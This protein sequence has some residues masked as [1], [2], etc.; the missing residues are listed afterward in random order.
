MLDSACIWPGSA[1]DRLNADLKSQRVFVLGWGEVDGSRKKLHK[2][3]NAYKE[4][5][6]W[7]ME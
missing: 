2:Q 7:I 4:V 6:M 1:L 5:E 3:E